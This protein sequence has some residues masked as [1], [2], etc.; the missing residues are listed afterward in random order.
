MADSTFT[1]G[2]NQHLSPD[3]R[4]SVSLLLPGP[5][6]KG[7]MFRGII[8]A[9]TTLPAFVDKETFLL[10]AGASTPF[11]RRALPGILFSIELDLVTSAAKF[12]VSLDQFQS[13]SGTVFAHL[14]HLQ[15]E[16]ISLLLKTQA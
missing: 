5:I 11:F 4:S 2:L 12:G 1:E 13:G 8:S 9:S 6:P 10:A 7:S 16:G 14:Q 3:I 15:G